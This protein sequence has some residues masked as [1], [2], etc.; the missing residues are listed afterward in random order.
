M[1]KLWTLHNI[2]LW[3]YVAGMAR[4]HYPD[5]CHVYRQLFVPELFGGL[6]SMIALNRNYGTPKHIDSRD[7]P[8]GITCTIVFGDFT[9]GETCFP[10]EQVMLRNVNGTVFLFHA[11][12]FQHCVNPFTGVRNSI[13]LFTPNAVVLHDS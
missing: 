11:A 8:P 4:K 3:K 13:S 7:Y 1:A 5:I 6:W 9:G 2:P 10:Q 12:L